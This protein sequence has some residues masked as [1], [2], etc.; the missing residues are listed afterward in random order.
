M[1]S[2]VMVCEVMI[3]EVYLDT[4]VRLDPHGAVEDELW[5]LLTVDD[6]GQHPVADGLIL[7]TTDRESGIEKGQFP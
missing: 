7:Q 5:S 3:S 2:E 1:I 4:A 6:S